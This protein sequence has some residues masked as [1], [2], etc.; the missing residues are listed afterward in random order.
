[1][2]HGSGSA[3][4]RCGST[5]TQAGGI[6]TWAVVV[7]VVGFFIVCVLSLLFLLIREDN[8]CMNCGWAWH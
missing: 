2:P 4:P 5:F 8:R 6:P 3:C 7:T 1:V